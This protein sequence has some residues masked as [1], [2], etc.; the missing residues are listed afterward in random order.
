M[1]LNFTEKSY[2]ESQI[3]TEKSYW[4]SQILTEKNWIKAKSYWMQFPDDWQ[5]FYTLF[6]VILIFL[7]KCV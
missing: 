2:S 5:V 1:R 4:E 7:Q 6:H 3:L